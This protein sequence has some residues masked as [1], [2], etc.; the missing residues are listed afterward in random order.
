[1]EAPDLPGLSDDNTPIPQVSLQGYA[2][3]IS[4]VLDAQPEPVVLVGQSS[5]GSVIS[6]AAE[7]RPDKIEMLVYVGAFLLRD[8]ETVLSASENDTESLV[9]ANLV[10]SGTDLPPHSGRTPSG[11]PHSPT[12]R[13]RTWSGRRPGSSPRPWLRSPLRFPSPKRTTAGY[14][15]CT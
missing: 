3:R 12:A 1:M 15:G 6:Q 9:L 4:G 11:K 7:Q 14:L 8:G 5:G 2:Q 10:M 13:S